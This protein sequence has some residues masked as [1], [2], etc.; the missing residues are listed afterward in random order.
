MYNFKAIRRTEKHKKKQKSKTKIAPQHLEEFWRGERERENHEF[1]QMK[2]WWKWIACKKTTTTN[3]S[4]SFFSGVIFSIRYFLTFSLS[5]SL[6]NGTSVKYYSSGQMLCKFRVHPDWY[7]APNAMF[8]SFN[9]N[10]LTDWWWLSQPSFLFVI[11]QRPAACT[12]WSRPS[13]N[14]SQHSL[15]IRLIDT[16]FQSHMCKICV[17]YLFHPIFI[18]KHSPNLLIE[19]KN[20][21]I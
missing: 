16:T 19:R 12:Q 5:L 3:R 10:C 9:R 4:C 11:F 1:Q 8:I 18:Q 15:P 7:N 2:I 13:A 20:R 14:I 6:R 21:R 17:N